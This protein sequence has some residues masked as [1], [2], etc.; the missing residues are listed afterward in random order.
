MTATPLGLVILVAAMAVES[1]AQVL[2][3]IGSAGGLAIL[4]PAIRRTTLR[5]VP[6]GATRLWIGLGVLAYGLEILLYTFALRYLDVSV[7]FPLGSLCF[8]GVALL[9]RLL[10]GETVGRLR[11][12][13]IG[14]I[15][16]GTVL[17]AL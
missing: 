13:G 12:L 14:L 8:V 3:K 5:L 15:L 6:A 9:S 11:W 10:L 17:V 1:L 7:A 2:L 16:A 4:R